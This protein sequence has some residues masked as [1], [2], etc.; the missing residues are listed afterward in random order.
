MADCLVCNGSGAVG[1]IVWYHAGGDP[2]SVEKDVELG[3]C[4]HCEGTGKV[5]HSL[6]NEMKRGLEKQSDNSVCEEIPF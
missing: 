1:E 5:S 2:E 6:F 4:E 3:P